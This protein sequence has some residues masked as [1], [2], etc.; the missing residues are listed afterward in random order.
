MEYEKVADLR[1]QGGEES[2]ALGDQSDQ[3]PNDRNPGV[4]SW[5]FI[6]VQSD[7]EEPAHEQSDDRNASHSEE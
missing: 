1:R 7:S 5:W 3:M 2:A 6:V 4:K